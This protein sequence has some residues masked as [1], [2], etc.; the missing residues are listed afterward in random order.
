MWPKGSLL[1]GVSYDAARRYLETSASFFEERGYTDL[2]RSEWWNA[3]Q[4]F[5]DGG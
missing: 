5:N 4:N 2:I 3:P 1:T